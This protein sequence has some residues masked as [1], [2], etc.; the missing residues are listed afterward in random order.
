MYGYPVVLTQYI[1]MKIIFPLSC[2]FIC[3]FVESQLAVCLWVYFVDPLFCSVGLLDHFGLVIKSP[4]ASAGDTRDT[5]SISGSGWGRSPG[6]GNGNPLWHSCLENPMDRGTWQATVH[7]VTK[8]WTRLKR[9]STHTGGSSG[10]ESTCNAGDP[11]SIPG[12][13][14]SPEEG[15]SYRLQYS[16]LENSMVRGAWQATVH[17]VTKSQTGLSG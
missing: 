1:E 8:S 12:L 17:A 6:E 5:S 9:H 14:R 4:S 11:G 3:T 2:P 7:R 16:C 15:N 10:K 13:G